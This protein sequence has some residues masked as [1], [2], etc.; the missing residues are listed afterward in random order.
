MNGVVPDP[1]QL[2]AAL[3]YLAEAGRDLSC[4]TLFDRIVERWCLVA[5]PIRD[6]AAGYTFHI[7]AD[8]IDVH[9]FGQRRYGVVCSPVLAVSM[10]GRLLRTRSK[11]YKL[12]GEAVE[13]DELSDEAM[14]W[15][16]EYASR[17]G[18]SID[19]VLPVESPL[20]FLIEHWPELPVLPMGAHTGTQQ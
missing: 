8:E 10:D 6:P 1:A 4:R 9:G 13:F 15:L 12:V 5:L 18:S 7:A 16:R 3:K 2:S 17:Q 20:S 11:W 19:D 14:H